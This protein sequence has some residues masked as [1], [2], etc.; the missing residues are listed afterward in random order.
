MLDASFHGE[1]GKTQ[2]KEQGL[3]ATERKNAIVAN[4]IK[5]SQ[6]TKREKDYFMNKGEKLIEM[7]KRAIKAKIQFEYL[8]VDSW[9]TNF[10]LIDF[11]C[12]CHKKFHLL[13]MSKMGNTKYNTKEWGEFTASAILGKL[14]SRK[15]INYNRKY[16]VITH[17]L[18]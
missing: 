16:C 15:A 5:E 2:G 14:K 18:Q 6:T 4:E 8:L 13:G 11:I 1:K 17:L 3:S 9:V 7:A 10:S 12:K